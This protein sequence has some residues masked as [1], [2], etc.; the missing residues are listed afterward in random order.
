MPNN[1]S[2]RKEALH[3]CPHQFA[4]MLDNWV[5]KLFQHPKRI[6]KE[7]IKEGD[8]VFDM[9]CGPGF[10]SVDMAEMVGSSGKV[11]AIDLQKK[12]L[13]RVEKKATKYGIAERMAY[14]RCEAARIGF[15]Q[16]ADF[17]LAFYVVH[18]TPD[19][20]AF[21]EEIKTMLKPDGKILAVE[22]TMHVSKRTF[23]GMLADAETAGLKAID[24]PRHKGGRS[25][26]LA[27]SG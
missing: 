15:P 22:P 11:V 9:G 3:V 7:Y 18:E 26:V 10:F 17:I 2:V 27:R 1:T 21:L 6:L 12:M 8:T 5:R 20:R 14:H 16:K 23:E 25:V 13:E 24:L 19:P 4:F